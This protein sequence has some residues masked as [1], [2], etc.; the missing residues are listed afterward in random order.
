MSR[1]KDRLQTIRGE[2]RAALVTFITAGDPAPG[3]TVPALHALVE[4]GA[5][6]LEI[7]VPFS[8]P[9][10]EG[11][12]IQASSE[13]ALAHGVTL[14]QVLEM[15]AEFRKRDATTPIVLMGYLNSVLRMGE[16]HFAAAAS[17]AGVDGLIMVNLPPEESDDLRAELTAHDIDLV[18]LVAPTTTKVR[19]DKILSLASGFVYY[20]SLKG[21]TGADHLDPAEIEA[22]VTAL[23]E[24]TDLPV[25]VGFGIKDPTSAGAVAAFADGVVVGSA[26]VRT[27]AASAASAPSTAAIERLGIALKEQVAA[28]RSAVDR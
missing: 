14:A 16:A 9:E 7:G 17:E 18:F 10:A 15:V 20:V 3:Y 19:A 23:R 11:P 12:A 5:D 4:A 26:I 27:M 28:L 24:R 13:R 8:D 25:M 21:I 2:D 1:L 6:V 22:R